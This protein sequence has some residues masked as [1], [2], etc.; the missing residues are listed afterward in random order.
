MVVSTMDMRN[1]FYYN[2][3]AEIETINVIIPQGTLGGI[4]E[5]TLSGYLM[6]A[7]IVVPQ[8]L[9]ELRKGISNVDVNPPII[10]V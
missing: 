8:L 2:I 5:N 7:P 3:L 10:T 1:I 9:L 4:I 6:T